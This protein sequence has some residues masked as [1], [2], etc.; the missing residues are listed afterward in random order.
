M[1]HFL[2]IFLGYKQSKKIVFSREIEQKG[3]LAF[4]MTKHYAKNKFRNLFKIHEFHQ[5]FQYVYDND[6]E[7]FFKAS[8]AIEDFKHSFES[9]C[10]CFN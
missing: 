9:N 5:L 4:E 2:L 1:S 3:Q 8:E 7:A 10:E 6:F